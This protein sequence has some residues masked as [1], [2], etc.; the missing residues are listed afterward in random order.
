MEDLSTKPCKCGGTMEEVIGHNHRSTDDTYV[1]YRVCWW[2][3]ECMAVD[4]CVGR[5]TQL[6]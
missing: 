2:C 4:R 6:K 1:A 5:E 3:Q